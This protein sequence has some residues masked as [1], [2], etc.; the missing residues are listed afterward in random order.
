MYLVWRRVHTIYTCCIASAASYGYKRQPYERMDHDSAA[1]G[2]W[3]AEHMFLMA[4][5]MVKVGQFKATFKEFPQR[6]KPGSF[7]P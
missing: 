6:Q 1:Y 3:W 7:V 4:P 2:T 5:S